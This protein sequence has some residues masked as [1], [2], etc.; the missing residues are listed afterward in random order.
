MESN[1]DEVLRGDS[2]SG[3]WSACPRLRASTN[4]HN[5]DVEMIVWRKSALD[6]KLFG[7]ESANVGVA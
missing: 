5:P 4:M 2:N 6:K 7:K 3:G 1:R